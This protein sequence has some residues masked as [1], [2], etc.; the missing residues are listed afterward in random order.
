MACA[1]IAASN[2]TDDQE[3]SFNLLLGLA[4]IF[5]W[6]NG[7]FWVAEIAHR[8]NTEPMESHN[9]F[10]ATLIARFVYVLYALI[11]VGMTLVLV[12]VLVL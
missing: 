7:L 6:S 12:L 11:L 9:S 8:R 4:V 2:S 3:S 10:S 5:G 1:F